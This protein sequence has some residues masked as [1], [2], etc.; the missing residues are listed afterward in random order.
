[1]IPSL[2]SEFRNS[3]TTQSNGAI[4][5]MVRTVERNRSHLEET[6]RIDLKLETDHTSAILK[7]VGFSRGFGCTKRYRRV[8]FSR[9][10]RS[11]TQRAPHQSAS[12]SDMTSWSSMT[13]R[14]RASTITKTKKNAM[15]QYLFILLLPTYRYRITVLQDSDDSMMR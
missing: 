2:F 7:N 4:A 13:A 12:L 5:T 1:V 11:D 8:C 6:E 10:T 3:I 14:P 9:N 15:T